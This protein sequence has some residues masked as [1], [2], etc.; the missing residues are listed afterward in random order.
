MD[1]SGLATIL[2]LGSS[3]FAVA[4]MYVAVRMAVT[5]RRLAIESDARYRAEVIDHGRTEQELDA[6][7]NRRRAAEDKLDEM[8]RTV[9][10]LE[11]K[12]ARLEARVA[13]LESSP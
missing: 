1:W 11:A 13:E 8:M 12:V 9:R 3:G 5:S 2:P 4:L 10:N 6:E 7:R